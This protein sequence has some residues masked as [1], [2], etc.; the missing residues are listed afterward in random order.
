MTK[1]SENA[2][3]SGEGKK[4]GSFWGDTEGQIGPRTQKTVGERDDKSNTG[5][6][7][8]NLSKKVTG[9]I[10]DN[11]GWDGW[12]KQQS[13][14]KKMFDF[15]T[16]KKDILEKKEGKW[17]GGGACSHG[18]KDF[19]YENIRVFLSAQIKDPPHQI[20]LSNSI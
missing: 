15:V 1:L 14:L 11:K 5:D 8:R 18:F 9:Q 2:T 4:K 10:P 6:N 13:Y 17:R 16:G 7:I 3:E 19:L 20:S 12:Q